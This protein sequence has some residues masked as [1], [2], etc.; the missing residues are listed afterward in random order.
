V[1][2]TLPSVGDVA[3]G[4]LNS[5]AAPLIASL[6]AAVIIRKKFGMKL[7]RAYLASVAGAVPAFLIYSL[8]LGVFAGYMS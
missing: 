5:L 8:L 2:W 7:G 6:I 3:A 1:A 4:W